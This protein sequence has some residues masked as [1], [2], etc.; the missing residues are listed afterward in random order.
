[1]R[2]APSDGEHE[3][4]A[5]SREI[6][7]HEKRIEA[8]RQE[9]MS[10]LTEDQRSE[11][12]SILQA[13]ASG[14]PRF[15]VRA[16]QRY[17][18][19]RV[20][21]L[22]W[23][24]ERF[25]KFDRFSIGDPGRLANKSERIGKKYQWIAYHEILAYISDHYQYRGRFLFDDEGGS[26]YEGPWQFHVRD[27]DP[28][29]TLRC[30]PGETSWGPHKPAWW[31]DARYAAWAE[32]LSHQGWLSLK[33][34]IPDVEELLQVVAPDNGVPWV[35]VRGHFVWRQSDPVDVDPF[36]IER[37]ELWLHWDAY[38]V[39]SGDVDSFMHWARSSDYSSRSLPEPASMYLY[40]MF[41]GEYG[42]SPAFG[43][44]FSGYDSDG[45]WATPEGGGCPVEVRPS[46][47]SYT[48]E[49]GGF[50]CSVD[51]HYTLHVPH[52]GL[53]DDLGLGW[54]GTAADYIDEGS[55]LAAFDPTAHENGPS[56]LLI[57]QELLQQ[58][59]EERGLALCWVV[60]GEKT[61]IGGRAQSK[62]QGR[63]EIS[64]AYRYTNQGPKGYL[65]FSLDL[66]EG[67]DS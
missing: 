6:E 32:E 20:F 62:F 10:A 13:K 42:W 54:S 16:I 17:V 37:R 9:L 30:T 25:G 36:R 60:Y 2:G 52:P 28:S 4:R 65:A 61:I 3:Q 5:L 45:G 41:F 53:L 23:T 64:G 43:H 56:V 38:F 27:I 51:E 40:Y 50:D 12:E 1:M 48:P 58:H 14:P 22:G 18:L 29:C 11:M 57:R 7:R 46:S 35:N 59:L 31:G 67:V 15:D 63:L 49:S 33:T 34:D 8:S 24:I 19:R 21:D 55:K 66:P 47:V 44:R 26:L 39:R